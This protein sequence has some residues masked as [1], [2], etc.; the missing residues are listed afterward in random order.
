LFLL[1]EVTGRG[2]DPARVSCEYPCEFAELAELASP[3]ASSRP[4][5]GDAARLT[6]ARGRPQATV[7]AFAEELPGLKPMLA[8]SFKLL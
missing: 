3:R 6:T 4:L 2:S 8:D 7:P 5:W 1:V